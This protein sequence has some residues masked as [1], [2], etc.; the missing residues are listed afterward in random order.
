MLSLDSAALASAFAWSASAL[1]SRSRCRRR[2]L[3]AWPP[4]RSSSACAAA[5]SA[6]SSS[7][8]VAARSSCVAP[9]CS[10]ELACTARPP[11]PPRL[12]S[13]ALVA[14][15]LQRFDVLPRRVELLLRAVESSCRRAGELLL[16]AHELLLSAVE[17]RLDRQCPD[18]QARGEDRQ[19]HA[20]PDPRRP[21]F[22]RRLIRVRD[23]RFT[24]IPCGPVVDSA[25]G[26]PDEV[27]SSVSLWVDMRSCSPRPPRRQRWCARVRARRVCTRI[28]G[29]GSALRPLH[30]DVAHGHG[31]R[32]AR[33]MIASVEPRAQARAPAASPAASLGVTLRLRPARWISVASTT[34]PG[35]RPKWTPSRPA[36]EH[37][38]DNDASSPRR[39]RSSNA[40]AVAE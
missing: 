4:P 34:A 20:E 14:V 3:P 30:E 27:S 12:R 31:P 22:R 29:L 17:V 37:A 39:I 18:Q 32:R 38:D 15:G 11:R 5:F 6:S 33:T 25:A 13:R 23:R 19:Q 2:R 40:S 7:C 35:S 8:W 16:R 10:R 36:R 26:P 28:A 1:L 21:A 24:A 9:S